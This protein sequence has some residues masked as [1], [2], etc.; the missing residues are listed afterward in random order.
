MLVTLAIRRVGAMR[1]EDACPMSLWTFMRARLTEVL[2]AIAPLVAAVCVL[3]V[4]IVHAPSSLFLQ[5]L[6]GAVLATLGMLLLLTGI[7]HGILPMGRYIGA[8][9]PRRGSAWLIVAV[10]A[11]FGFVTTVA[12]PDVLVL[13]SQ[14]ASIDGSPVGGPALTYL[15]ASG[16]GLFTAAALW[17]IAHG[18]ALTR[19]LS[20]AFALMVLLS[21]LSPPAFLALAYDAG[22][23]T[24]GVLSG[25]V[26]LALGLGLSAVL[27]RRAGT[28]DGFG[29]LGLASTG[30][31]IVV[32]LFGWLR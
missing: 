12:E 32:L 7:E 8:E 15:I 21:L 19:L 27:A 24:T 23:V 10:A 3:Q 20:V 6:G 28:L 18:R 4:T 25:P 22:S 1:F 16:V 11:A 31:V 17:R 30:P 26:L 9:L 13:A 29:L 14:V 5:F 2:R